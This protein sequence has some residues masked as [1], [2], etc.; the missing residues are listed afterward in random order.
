MDEIK[1]KTG[2]FQTF[3]ATRSFALGALNITV[4][5][6]G[7][8]E[9][10]GT[11]VDYAGTRYTF[12]QLRGATKAGWLVLA[13]E[14]KEGSSEYGRSVSA[15]IKV[16][17]LLGSTKAFEGLAIEADERIVGNSKEH[18]ASVKDQNKASKTNKVS[19]ANQG[20]VQE[21]PQEGVPVRTLK[22]SAKSKASLTANSA[23]SL[24]RSAENVQIKA[25]QGVTEE[26]ALKN[27]SDED[28]ETYLAEKDALRSRHIGTQSPQVVGQVKTAK[29]KETE[30]IK[31]TQQVGGGIEIADMA[32]MGGKAKQ[33]T[34]VEDGI[35]FKNTNGPERLQPE[36]H[37]RSPRQPVML[38]DGTADAR[39]LIA[40]TICP[41]FP[42]NYDFAASSKKKLAR[43]QADFEGRPDVLKAVFVAE[44]DEMKAKLVTEFPAIFSR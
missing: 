18:T 27:M 26:E 20:I 12:P 13:S 24:I 3:V 17:P 41:E 40:R 10:D 23:G 8:V 31:L 11:T 30:G 39:I 22:T 7:E 16:K 1:F 32:G 2:V 34:I 25:G 15:N 43:L 5:I 14:Y 36:D 29:T 33:S 28:R 37:P 42:S 6:G 35:T 9:F 4:A 38:K 21:D 19:S 44:S